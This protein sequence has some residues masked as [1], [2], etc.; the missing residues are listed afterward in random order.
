MPELLAIPMV[1]GQRVDVYSG[2]ARMSGKIWAT[3]HRAA[4]PTRTVAIV[5][6]PAS[7]FM[8]HYLLE[9]LSAR[10]IDAVGL[11]TRYLGNDSALI[12]ENVVL[13]MGAAISF[14]R[15]RGY[16]RV[17][18]I[19]NSGGGGAAALYQAQAEH[20]SITHTPAGDPVDLTTADLPRA[21]ALVTLMAHP[22]RAS[23][24]T[25]WLDP[26]I[27]DETDPTRRDPDLDLYAESRKAPY[28]KDFLDRYRAAQLARNRRITAWVHEQLDELERSG[29]AVTDL[30]FVVH[31]TAADPRFLDLTLDPSDRTS[32]TL[33]GPPEEANMIP[34]TL[35]HYTSLRS[36]LSQWSID[37]TNCDGPRQLPHTS[38]PTLVMYGTADQVCFPSY[39]QAMYDAVPHERKKLVPVIG[40]THYL[41][42]QEEQIA[43]VADQ[44]A[45]WADEHFTSAGEQ[46]AGTAPAGGNR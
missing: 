10:G 7:N 38:V 42:G 30:P 31:G 17:I 2:I 29:S 16:Q 41:Q 12:M 27:V 9:P 26:A 32:G 40:G 13:D 46:L 44:V 28:D 11:T 45:A 14:L 6:H 43:F 22:G 21:D 5:T 25:D 39:A 1:T 23:V 33:W 34:A 36:W 8:G 20:P 37:E 35:G 15:S 19:G 24:Y 4:T 3:L 18:L